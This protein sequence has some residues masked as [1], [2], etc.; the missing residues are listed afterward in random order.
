[1]KTKVELTGPTYEFKGGSIG[2]IDGYVILDN[3]SRPYAIVG[4]D[5][6]IGLVPFSLLKVTKIA[7]LS[8]ETKTVFND[9]LW[10]G[11]QDE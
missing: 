2:Y 10:K 7:E 5:E 4:V 8:K 11:M 3:S 9:E 1:M 6:R